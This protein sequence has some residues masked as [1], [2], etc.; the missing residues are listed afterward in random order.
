MKKSHI[1]IAITC[2][3]FSCFPNKQEQYEEKME[4]LTFKPYWDEINIFKEFYGRFPDSLQEVYLFYEEMNSD[5][6]DEIEAKRL[7]DVFSKNK[8]WFGYF[9]IYNHDGSKVISYAILSAG[10]DGKLNNIN[11]SEKL[12][13]NDWKQKLRLYNP[14]EFDDGETIIY[15]DDVEEFEFYDYLIMEERPYCAKEAK[16]G[17]KDL[18]VRVHHLD[19]SSRSQSG[20]VRPI[21]TKKRKRGLLLTGCTSNNRKKLDDFKMVRTIFN[22]SEIEHLT[23]I[24]N[25]F[26]SQICAIEGADEANVIEC[27]QRFFKRLERDEV[28]GIDTRISLQEQHEMYAQISEST[29]NQIWRFRH[30]YISHPTLPPRDTVRQIHLIHRSKYMDFV[31]K[32]G[33]EYDV[34]KDYFEGLYIAGGSIVPVVL[35]VVYGYNDFNIRDPRVQL[36]I[37]IHYLTWNDQKTV[38][39]DGRAGERP[40]T[41]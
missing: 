26:N 36:V 15:P 34:F 32:L 19:G 10:I 20:D 39:Y 8:E 3:L 29:F 23:T 17:D 22:Q 38:R 40:E 4:E 1:I 7:R 41:F 27:Y 5:E 37:A 33:E 14:D 13:I 21:K 2:L 9:P 28:R 18:L 25:F 16:S 11:L 35:S 24:L 6:I 12:Y 30:T 31:R